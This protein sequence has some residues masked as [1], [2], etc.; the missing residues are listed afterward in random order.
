M[1]TYYR[2]AEFLLSV[3]VIIGSAASVA[4]QA[5]KNQYFWGQFWLIWG[6]QA[7]M[8]ILLIICRSRPAAIIGSAL[9]LS[10][11]EVGFSVYADATND[12][13][14][15]VW[16]GYFFS[17][18]GAAIGGVIAND[19]LKAESFPSTGIRVVFKM[20]VATLI[21]LTLNQAV[22]CSTVMY[23]GI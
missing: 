3:I 9:V 1:K 6:P 12:V 18:P 16:L 23:C 8:L 2:L 20:A 4:A 7:A 10:L 14:G 21:G 13:N 15:L 5:D 17:F 22:I 19:R 11:Y